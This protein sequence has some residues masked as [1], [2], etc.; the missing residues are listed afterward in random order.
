MGEVIDGWRVSSANIVN[1]TFD[2][3]TVVV[4]LDSGKYY[5]LTGVASVLW[6]ALP[7]QSVTAL[8]DRVA[9]HYGLDRSETRR[10]IERFVSSL[11]D[12]G[13]VVPA[14]PAPAGDAPLASFPDRYEAPQVDTYDDMQDLLL[15]DPIH[16]VDATGWPKRA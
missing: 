3:E 6:A 5:S 7:S 4:N 8:V 13:L 16:D 15:L 14:D 2:D 1:E 9:G 12:E 11:A 10:E